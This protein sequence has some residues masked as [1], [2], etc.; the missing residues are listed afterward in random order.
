MRDITGLE[1]S[2]NKSSFVLGRFGGFTLIEILIVVVIIALL[3][4]LVVP[5]VA[6]HV[7]GAR[8][9]T[10]QTQIEML[11]SALD[12]FQLDVGRYPTSAEGLGALRERPPTVPVSRWRGPYLR[13]R[14]PADPWGAPYRYVSPGVVN[15]TSYD[16]LS[17][18]A[19][20]REG[21]SADAAD[22]VSW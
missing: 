14:V 19:D 21:G 13:R 5:N 15:P 12:A 6:Q 17:L 16:L 7:G 9:T 2:R 11:G 3:A 18:G 4:S 10:A 20:G 22:I 8:T 1:L